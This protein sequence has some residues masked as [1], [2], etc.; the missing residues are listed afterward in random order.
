MKCKGRRRR[1]T[2]NS[3]G[4]FYLGIEQERRHIPYD[5][6]REKKPGE[7]FVQ[8]RGKV[9][10]QRK[11]QSQVLNIGEAEDNEDC[12]NIARIYYQYQVVNELLWVQDTLSVVAL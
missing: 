11:G 4:Y 7:Q 5:A 1:K 12:E 9:I 10:L 6:R 2:R 3:G 8:K